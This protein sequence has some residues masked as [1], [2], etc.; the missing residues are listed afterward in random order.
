MHKIAISGDKQVKFF[1]KIKSG[2]N[3]TVIGAGETKKDEQH[4]RTN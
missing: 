1:P 2:V 3:I 4:P